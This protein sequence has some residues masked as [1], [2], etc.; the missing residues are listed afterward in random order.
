M[1]RGRRSA[2]AAALLGGTLALGVA[3]AAAF[4]HL[5]NVSEVYSNADGS[6]QFV[7]L[8]T[9]GFGEIGF[10]LAALDSDQNTLDGFT[11]FTGNTSSRHV[12]LATPGFGDLPGGVEP[13][14]VLP[15]GF[16]DLEGD[17][18]VF[19]AVNLAETWDEVSFGSVPADG[20]LSLH[21]VDPGAVDPPQ[22]FSVAANTPTNYAGDV[23]SVI[24]PEPPRDVLR[25]LAGAA[26]L[27]LTRGRRRVGRAQRPPAAPRAASTLQIPEPRTAISRKIQ[28]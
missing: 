12:L 11:D 27:A 23:G 2:G 24:L 17:T 8:F 6:V 26:L 18:L 7:E 28:L 21:R 3:P 4:V 22:S 25:I 1:R 10:S 15:P 9:S 14:F 5:W 13:D 19:R 16:F 20:T